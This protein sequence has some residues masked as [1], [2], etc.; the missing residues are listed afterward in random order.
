MTLDTLPVGSRFKCAGLVARLVKLGPCSATVE[1]EKP[2]TAEGA[3]GTRTVREQWS[4][5]SEVQP[6]TEGQ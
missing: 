6:L 4:T 3:V 2:K 1:F 5:K